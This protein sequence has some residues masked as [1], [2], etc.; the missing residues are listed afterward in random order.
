MNRA[1]EGSQGEYPHEKETK[2]KGVTTKETTKG[3]K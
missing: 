2:D 3:G 1:S